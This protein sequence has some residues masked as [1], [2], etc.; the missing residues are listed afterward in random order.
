MRFDSTF[1]SPALPDSGSR[2]WL[3]PLSRNAAPP[4]LRFTGFLKRNVQGRRLFSFHACFQTLHAD[5][6]LL[7]FTL[8]VCRYLYQIRFENPFGFNT[9]M[10]TGTALFSRLTFPRDIVSRNGSFSANFTSSGHIFH[11]N[12]ILNRK[13]FLTIPKKTVFVKRI[14]EE[15]AF[16]R[17][18][19]YFK[20]C[21]NWF[22]R[23][24]RI[25][26]RSFNEFLSPSLP[27]RAIYPQCKRR[28]GFRS[29]D[30][31]K[32]QP[33]RRRSKDFFG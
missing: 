26:K 27:N 14:R 19:C 30:Y 22:C 12:I 31:R 4:A 29:P 8:N 24:R 17:S 18:F 23:C 32:S 25:G 33:R 9:D 2:S 20:T 13:L 3:S 6:N 5:F 10:L 7:R 15:I 1:P 16:S 11:L 28:F 21:T